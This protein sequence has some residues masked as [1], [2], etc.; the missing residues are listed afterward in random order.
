MAP[1][2]ITGFAGKPDL[3]PF[4]DL[5]SELPAPADSDPFLA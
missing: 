5:P 3:Y 2:S 1:F 4:F